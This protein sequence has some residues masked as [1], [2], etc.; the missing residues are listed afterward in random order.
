MLKYIILIT[1]KQPERLEELEKQCKNHLI[2]RIFGAAAVNAI[3]GKQS[4]PGERRE[5]TTGK[6]ATNYINIF[7]YCAEIFKCIKYFW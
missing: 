5:G 7:M 6:K 1:K 2:N 4:A 3:P